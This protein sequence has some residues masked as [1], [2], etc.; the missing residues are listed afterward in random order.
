MA[1]FVRNA[2]L[3]VCADSIILGEK[4]SHK[5][6]NPLKSLNISP[7][8]V[9]DNPNVDVR[10]SGHADLSVLHSGGD[11]LF[12]APYL[13][14][15]EFAQNIADMGADIEFADILQRDKYPFDAQLNIALVGNLFIYNSRVSYLSVVKYL[16]IERGFHGINCR[17]G[18][19]KCSVLVV[20]E[21]S[22]IT[23]DRGIARVANVAG[24]NVLE[25]EAGHVALDGFEYGFIGGA[26]F[27]L[28]SNVLAFTGKIDAHPDKERILAFI[29]SRNIMPV[30]LTDEPVFDIGSAIILTEKH[31]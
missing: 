29:S 23:Q 5:L 31:R 26:G 24:L 21:S 14:R 6:S 20:D 18:Y 22:I 2:N 15:T 12:L 3:P 10:L 9:P 13:K 17:Q 8:F 30:Y 7:I 4:Y 1:D 16:T 25:I 28:S 27:K 19:A 11:K